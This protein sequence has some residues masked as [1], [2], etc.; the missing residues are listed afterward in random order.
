MSKL[1]FAQVVPRLLSGSLS[2][3]VLLAASA[4]SLVAATQ[5]P[6]TLYHAIDTPRA[7]PTCAVFEPGN[8]NRLYV[9][10]KETGDIWLYEN[11]TQVG[12][13]MHIDVSTSGERGLMSMV[14]DP[15]FGTGAGKNGYFYVITS[16]PTS[17][18]GIL[19]RYTRDASDPNRGDP[20]SR[21]ELFRNPRDLGSDIH[22][23]SWMGFTPTALV[24][25][26][27]DNKHWLYITV[28]DAGNGT[29]AQTLSVRSGK[30]LRL[31]VDPTRYGTQTT[32]YGIPSDN[33]WKT[34]GSPQNEIIA[35]GVRNPWRGGFDRVTGDFWLCD[36]GAT[37]RE[38]VNKIPY[39][40][41][42]GAGAAVI[43]LGWPAWEGLQRDTNNNLNATV[44]THFP[45]IR[46]FGPGA[47]IGGRVYRGAALPGWVGS[48]IWTNYG[49]QMLSFLG[50]DPNNLRT[51][52]KTEIDTHMGVGLGAVVSY[53]EDS[54]GELYVTVFDQ[55]G[56]GGGSVMRLSPYDANKR[57]ARFTSRPELYA[58][59]DFSYDYDVIVDGLPSVSVSGTTL[60]AGMTLTMGAAANPQH[61]TLHWLPSALGTYNVSLKAQATGVNPAAYQ[62]FSLTVQGP[63]EPD[64]APSDT[65]KVAAGLDWATFPDDASDGYWDTVPD[66]NLL[67]PAQR[68]TISTIAIVPPVVGADHIAVR[69]QGYLKVDT[70]GVYRFKATADDR[71]KVL[72][73]G[74]LIYDYDSPAARA[75]PAPQG[76]ISLQ[77]GYHRLE[78]DYLEQAGGEAISV[79]WIPV[80]GSTFTDIPAANLYRPASGYAYG[81]EGYTGVAPYL[82]VFPSTLGGGNPPAKLSQTGAFANLATL[83]PA[84]GV[85]P[86][87]V[88]SPLWSD[89]AAKARWMAVPASQ[90]IGFDA[91]GNWAFPAGTVLI[92]HFAIDTPN[93]QQRL[94][95]R[96][97]IMSSGGAYGVTY[98]WNAAG[99]D[100]DLDSGDGSTLDVTRAD[101]RRQTWT[102][103]SR[104][105]CMECHLPASGF[106]LGLRT[107]QMNGPQAYTTADNLTRTDN[108]LRALGSAGLLS[109][110][111]AEGL[112]PGYPK[113]VKVDDT[114]AD[115][116]TRVRSYLDANCAHCHQPGGVGT[117]ALDT[118]FSATG[119]MAGI[120]DQPASLAIPGTSNLKLLASNDPAHSAIYLRMNTTDPTIRMPRLARALIHPQAV[121]AVYEYITSRNNQPVGNH[122]PVVNA[123]TDRAITVGYPTALIAQVVNVSAQPLTMAWSASPAT[124]VT[125]ANGTTASPTITVASA[126]TYTLT[127]TATAGGQSA[128][129]VI[130]L[131]A[132]ANTAPTITLAGNATAFVSQPL[133]LRPTVSDA[134]NL[135]TGSLTYAWSVVSGPASPSFAP[136]ATARDADVTFTAGG[137]YVLRLSASDGQLTTTADLTVSVDTVVHA[138]DCGNA[139][140]TPLTFS[141]ITYGFDPLQA[142]GTDHVQ[143]A[144]NSDFA[145]TTMDALYRTNH[146]GNAFSY[147]FT[148]LDSGGTYRVRV[149]TTEI[150]FTA[151]G[152]RVFNVTANGT[153]VKQ[154]VDAFALGGAKYVAS[155]VVTN[156]FQPPGNGQ[157][158]IGF[159]STAD[160]ALVCALRLERVG[161][162]S[163]QVNQPP[164]ATAA[165][166]T[167]AITLPANSVTLSGTASDPEGRALAYQWQVSTGTAANVTFSAGTALSTTA[168]FSAAGTYGFKLKATDDAP[169]STLSNEVT[170]VVSPA[171]SGN[172]WTVVKA[173]DCGRVTGPALV[174]DGI[175]WDLDTVL[176]ADRFEGPTDFGGTTTL[177][178]VYRSNNTGGNFTYSFSGLA[179]GTYRARVKTTEVYFTAVGSRVFNVNANGTAVATGGDPFALG[180]DKFVAS[181]AVTATFSP[182]ANGAVALNFVA[183]DDAALVT[184]VVLEKQGGAVNQPPTVSVAT[185]A[186][187]ITLPT[188]VVTLSGTATDPEAH[189]MTYQWQVST[190]TAANVTFSAATAA[191]TAATFSAAGTYGFKLTVTDDAPQSV[192]S[193]E[194]T[195]VVS[196]AASGNGWTV[197]KAI[198]C[199]RKTG[200]A[201]VA[202]GITWDLDTV[203][204][205]DRFEGP[206]DFAGTTTL[207]EVYRSNNT[208]A[209]AY[210]FTGLAAGTYHARVK[211]TEVWFTQA[212]GRVFSVTANGTTVAS[213]ID[214]YALGG[215]LFVASEVPTATFSPDANGT[216]TLAFQ[217][218][219]DAALVT[220]L[221]LE[222]QGGAVNQPPTVNA[223]A[224][225]NALT[226]PTN[227][228]TLSGTATDPEGR[229]L[230]YQWQVST[231]TAANVTFSTATAASTTAT[232]SAAGTYGF[233]L[234]VTDD[235]PQ[236]VLSSEVTVVVSPAAGN[237]WTVVSAIDCGRKTGTAITA[238]VITWGLDTVIGGDR[239]EGPTDFAGTTTLDEVYR[240]NNTGGNFTYSFTG[241]AAGTYRARVQTTEVY[242]TKTGARVFN[243]KANGTTVATG[244]DPYALGGAKF[245]ASDAATAT[246]SPDAN[247]TVALNFVATTDAALVCAIVL[248]KQSAAQAP[249]P[250]V[251]QRPTATASVNNGTLTLPA[252]QVTLTGTA[253]DPEGR[254]LTYLWTVVSG[255]AANVTLA[256]PTALSTTA[257]FAAAGIYAFQLK[258]TDDAPQSTLSAQVTVT[259][260][261]AAVSGSTIQVN[262]QSAGTVPAGYIADTGL[263]YAARNGQTYGWNADISADTRKRNVNADPRLDTLIHVAKNG[264]TK[265]WE[266]ALPN[267]LYD[268]EVFAGDPSYTD[269]TNTFDVEGQVWTDPTPQTSNYDHFIIRV[270]VSDG[271]L[272]IK[273][274]TAGANA[275]LEAVKI[276]NVP[277]GSG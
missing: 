246:F 191:N 262:F 7:H 97:L 201:I 39:S 61:A 57:P 179:A 119:T 277:T 89:D 145:N 217:A 276:T 206:T 10:E 256:T 18:A 132:Q 239:F 42:T 92:K 35:I 261:P 158:V 107:H 115:I 237:T 85:L 270:T 78:L 79:Q 260:N 184:A 26:N 147:T 4:G 13:F 87:N 257:T 16:D 130:V 198:D 114:T 233:K 186:T 108:Q 255:T 169:Q 227:A 196:P 9:L 200:P 250:Q 173:I 219:A 44:P 211:T 118:R 241:L 167:N 165:V 251:N 102:F 111:Y 70:A 269:M 22:Y 64:V 238:D 33:P 152:N 133:A 273:Q 103:P 207:D 21:L 101:G 86:Y 218:T 254:A 128:S 17:G 20:T 28:G 150:Y 259:V 168:T 137:T 161:G 164:S 245:V 65:T 50:S 24:T 2:A 230:T 178:E 23:G 126:G 266:M 81:L 109:Q 214:P 124:G 15:D 144:P 247:G 43:N 34:Q 155:E 153:L 160:A 3:A 231:G 175:T 221:V 127:A 71:V 104:T 38:E 8:D 253:S 5:E 134:D 249:Q 181:E 229:A 75:N 40:T 29:N 142:A 174:A 82:G 228:V 31:D 68:G 197:V 244:V 72:V 54:Q 52:L 202:D 131:T 99:T 66:F 51:D 210:S 252:N 171:A 162:G 84:R 125:I 159:Q 215:V 30:I 59:K 141:G 225:V 226:L 55:G 105:N 149:M 166:S 123:G 220:A 138:I 100:A 154:G 74:R 53:S 216:V 224:S 180:G 6:L 143:D 258:V 271:K 188:N 129:D 222:K 113:S 274:A 117:V 121:D 151:A 60:P 234:Q 73:A 93:G 185:S 83:T 1:S 240:S 243:V 96:F 139:K 264:T 63:R 11:G 177:D 36:V 14:I 62:N 56:F 263:V 205:G 69:Y 140:G 223:S 116:T 193:S 120:L 192:V 47:F 242:F 98:K 135:P 235:D 76:S 58:T 203:I 157:V 46:D 19:A 80:G 27:P 25:S 265:I 182:D 45:P 268:V 95:T 275:K 232:F 199:G 12:K 172:G 110:P 189:A 208:G 112:I 187:A 156:T 32:P 248:E 146:S 236:S 204:G 212:G 91:S 209:F 77:P 194:V 163:A 48:Y 122:P 267:G 37:S 49:S 41:F 136:S 176:A 88:N 90:T 67:T 170:V 183:T 213:G 272:T 106:A 190:G 148:G 195:V 94:E